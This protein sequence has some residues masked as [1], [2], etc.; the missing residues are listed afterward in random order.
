[1]K[2]K[3]PNFKHQFVMLIDDNELDNF[4]NEKMIE[5]GHFSE[6]IYVNSSGVSALEFLKNLAVSGINPDVIYP[7]VLFID[8]NMPIMD[9]FQFI[10]NLRAIEG[11]KFA[12]CKLVILT[13]SVF[14]EDREK[15]KTAG[16]NIVFLNKPL[17]AEMLNQI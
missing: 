10:E 1:M 6:K 11:N 2:R 16:G 9:G 12:H 13:S 8:I 3:D 5:A 4:L 14:S 17:T 15:A 7:E